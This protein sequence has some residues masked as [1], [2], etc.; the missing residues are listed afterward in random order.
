LRTN[1]RRRKKDLSSIIGIEDKT[2]DGDRR[3]VFVR[4]NANSTPQAQNVAPN[5]IFQKIAYFPR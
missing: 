5:T 3:F 1:P 2:H 4:G